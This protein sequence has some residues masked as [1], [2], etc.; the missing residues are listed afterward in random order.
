MTEPS[1]AVVPV[2][3]AWYSKINWTQIVQVVTTLLTTNAFGFDAETQVQVLTY[4]TLATNVGTIVLKTWF[5]PSVTPS[6]V[7]ATIKE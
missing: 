6:S 5:S 4:T 7:S 3:P 2:K 1:V